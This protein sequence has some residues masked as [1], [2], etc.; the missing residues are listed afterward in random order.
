MMKYYKLENVKKIH[1]E[2]AIKSLIALT[3]FHP[4]DGRIKSTAEG[5]YGKEQGRLYVAED[6]DQVV[7]I[8]G[9][10]RVDNAF[11]EIMHFIVK[12]DKRG[13]GVGQG[14]IAC[15]KN[16]ERVDEIKTSCN[17]KLVTFY[18]KLGFKCKETE[19]PVTFKLTYDCKLKLD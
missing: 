5:I 10:R 9:V 18:E 3:M 19:D 2:G 4:T 16:N 13:Q 14:L 8:L 1:T 15:L 17:E 7:G 12:E 6:E 11:V